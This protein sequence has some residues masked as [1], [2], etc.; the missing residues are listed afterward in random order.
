MPTVTIISPTA[1][2]TVS[3]TVTVSAIASDDVGVTDVELY[4]NE[5]YVG[6]MTASPYAV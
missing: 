2:S 3:G 4:V 5:A 1:G 6:N